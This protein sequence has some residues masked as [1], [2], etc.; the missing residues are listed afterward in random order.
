M[1]NYFCSHLLKLVEGSIVENRNLKVSIYSN[2]KS[3][4]FVGKYNLMAKSS[5]DNYEVTIING[6]LLLLP[7]IEISGIVLI[8]LI[9]TTVIIV[10]V[11]RRKKDK[12]NQQQFFDQHFKR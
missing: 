12:G 10:K 4:S 11:V 6:E 2:A 9:V 5:N 1:E 3:M 8:V 7:S